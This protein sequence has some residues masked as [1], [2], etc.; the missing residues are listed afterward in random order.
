MGMVFQHFNLFPNL[1]VMEQHHPG[2]GQAE[3]HEDR[4]RRTEEAMKLLERV[5]LADK[6]DAYPGPALRRPEAAHRHRPG[7]GHEA[8][9]DAV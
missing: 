9:G 7:A 4:T 1:T 6:A 5:G 3:A 2:P 8:Q